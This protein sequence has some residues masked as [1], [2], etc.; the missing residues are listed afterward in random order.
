MP[1]MTKAFA[2]IAAVVLLAALP[3]PAAGEKMQVRDLDRTVSLDAN[4][5]VS[6]KSHKGSIQVETWGEARAQVSARIEPDTGCGFDPYQNERV[7]R[8][9]IDVETTPSRLELH[10][11]YDRLEDF[12]PIRLDIPGLEGA[13]CSAYPFIHYRLRIPA[14]ARLEIEDHKSNIDVAGLRGAT[15][16]SSHKGDV[17]VKGQAGGLDLTTHK[18]EV[19]VEFARLAA[20][21]RLTTHKGDI[22][23]SLP[24]SAGF[25]LDARVEG[26]G[27]LDSSFAVAE[28]AVDRR[29]RVSEQSINGGGPRLELSTHKGSLTLKEN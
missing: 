8:T 17:H 5:T 10:S 22:E 11:N 23:V 20:D 7:E 24:R 29:S 4:G 6:I 15:R 14:T 25:D 2:G 3:L 1:A 9:R 13:T 19:R 27:R 16:I 28:R 26:G 21:S 18:G 12:E